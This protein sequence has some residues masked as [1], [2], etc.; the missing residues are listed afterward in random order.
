[1]DLLHKKLRN[2]WDLLTLSVE[3]PDKDVSIQILYCGVCHSDLH[4][5]RNEWKGTMYPCVPGHE[6]VGRVTQ[7]GKDVK[8]FKEGDCAA[9]G[10]KVNSGIFLR[11]L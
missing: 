4:T 10:C 1:M 8:G 9:V 5:A 3:I 7:V 11:V 6:I 2:L